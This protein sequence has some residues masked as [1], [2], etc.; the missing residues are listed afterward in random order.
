MDVSFKVCFDKTHVVPLPPRHLSKISLTKRVKSQKMVL[1]FNMLLLVGIVGAFHGNVPVA[2]PMMR[3]KMQMSATG[4]SFNKVALSA[5]TLLSSATFA[6]NPA[7]A[8][9]YGGFGKAPTAVFQA[10]DV[11]IVEVTDDVKKGKETLD[12]TV[13]AVK[14]IRAT[15][16]NNAQ[17]DLI[18]SVKSSLNAAT[19]RDALNK[20]NAAFDE[21]T[22]RGTDRLI[23]VAL[24]D[25]T[26]LQRDVVI[27][28]GKTR[29]DTKVVA[30]DKRL[31][32]LED[33]LTT[34]CSYLK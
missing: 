8:A 19:L 3:S 7:H 14:E 33:A 23:R 25:I 12:K 15:L 2:R 4:S 32:A 30:I 26:E 10:S 22:Q 6:I 17:A 28:D 1:I 20:Y 21:N 9:Q 34:L 29:A 13:A 24:Q 5:L 16:K 31:A 18:A 11:V 27:K